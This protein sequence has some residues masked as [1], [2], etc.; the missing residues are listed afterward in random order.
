MFYDQGNYNIRCEWGA[1]GIT[2][3]APLCDVVI[4]VDVLSFSTCVDVAVGRGAEVYPFVWAGQQGQDAEK[5][6][7][8]IGAVV[9]SS[10]RGEEGWLTL[11][12]SSLTGIEAGTRLVLPSP[13]GATL[14]LMTG[15]KATLAGCLRNAKSVAEAALRAGSNILVVPAGERW[16]DGS[17]RPAIEDLIGAG[18]I[19][20]YLIEERS[21]SPES[22]IA[23]SAYRAVAELHGTLAECS[24]GRELIERGFRRDVERAAELNCSRCAPVLIGGAYRAR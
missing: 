10:R 2:N 24:S 11:S 6:A 14:S 22:S 21:V 19:I 12:P 18:A 17:L 20:S 13:N 4:I 3:L 23:L 1:A 15:E 7:E 8:K 9:A 5:Y 16:A